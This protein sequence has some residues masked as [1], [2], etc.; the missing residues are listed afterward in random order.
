[1]RNAKGVISVLAKGAAKVSVRLPLL[2]MADK[3]VNGLH[4]RQRQL[5]I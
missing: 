1:M 5:M 4:G 3:S 2:L